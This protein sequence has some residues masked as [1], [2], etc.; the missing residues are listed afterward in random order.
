MSGRQS[1]AYE[2]GQL[3]PMRLIVLGTEM[4]YRHVCYMI[5]NDWRKI[6]RQ[7]WNGNEVVC[8]LHSC[9]CFCVFSKGVGTSQQLQGP[10]YLAPVTQTCSK[11]TETCCHLSSRLLSSIKLALICQSAIKYLSSHCF[12]IH[13]CD[14]LHRLLCRG[15]V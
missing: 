6:N 15:L 2:N 10:L 13:A 3:K 7:N 4:I 11:C 5:N 1:R 12:Y 14:V 8:V 9:N